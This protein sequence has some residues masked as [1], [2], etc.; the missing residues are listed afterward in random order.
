MFP[1]SHSGVSRQTSTTGLFDFSLQNIHKVRTRS[2]I[3]RTK[4]SPAAVSS[5]RLGPGN[6]GNRGYDYQRTVVR[7]RL[8][9]IESDD[10]STTSAPKSEHGD[11]D[12]D[13]VF[14]V[15]E[16]FTSPRERPPSCEAWSDSANSPRLRGNLSTSSDSRRSVPPE[17][18][19]EC[20]T[21]NIPTEEG[22]DDVITKVVVEAAS[23]S[24]EA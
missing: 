23:D 5:F 12:I 1:C 8:P 21:N 14:A 11:S 17:L 20:P 3:Q 10:M 24:A 15:E 18:R 4:S 19:L 6:D 22:T 16:D 13:D 2:A 7:E 9:L